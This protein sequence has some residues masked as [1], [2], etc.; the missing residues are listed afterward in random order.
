VLKVHRKSTWKNGRGI[1]ART[2]ILK[3]LPFLR[4][5]GVGQRFRREARQ[6]TARVLMFDCTIY[7]K[8]CR[9]NAGSVFAEQCS[10]Y[11]TKGFSING[12]LPSCPGGQCHLAFLFLCMNLE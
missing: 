10:V 3:N 11:I 6:I 5:E 12:I 2:R 4:K 1:L 8:R 9:F 7:K